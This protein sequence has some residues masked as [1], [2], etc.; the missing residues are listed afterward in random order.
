MDSKLYVEDYCIEFLFN[1]SKVSAVLSFSLTVNQRRVTFWKWKL[2]GYLLV[3]TFIFDSVVK[4][5]VV[6][7]YRKREPK[8]ATW[9]TYH[10]LLGLNKILPIMLGQLFSREPFFIRYLLKMKS[11]L[12]GFI[13]LFIHF[14]WAVTKENYGNVSRPIIKQCRSKNVSYEKNDQS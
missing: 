9:F 12:T 7:L 13:R 11:W 6:F 10:P 1:D 4:K 2:G 14:I 5:L 8:R 3:C